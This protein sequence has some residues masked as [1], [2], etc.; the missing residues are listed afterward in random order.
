MGLT[1]SVSKAARE[2]IKDD[3]QKGTTGEKVTNEEAETARTL[4]DALGLQA[5]VRFKF[6]N[7]MRTQQPTP[8]LTLTAGRAGQ[9]KRVLAIEYWLSSQKCQAAKLLFTL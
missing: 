6:T 8:Q 5:P 4:N 2:R 7:T 3:T 9:P 1:A